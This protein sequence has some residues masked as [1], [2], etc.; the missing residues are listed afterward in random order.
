MKKNLLIYSD[1]SKKQLESLKEFYVQKKIDSMSYQALKK[2]VQEV[3]AAE[4]EAEFPEGG[5]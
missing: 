1:L 2:Y 5:H 3:N 4:C